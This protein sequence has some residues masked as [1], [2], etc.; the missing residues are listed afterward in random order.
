MTLLQVRISDGVNT[1]GI[2]T[3]STFAE[4][5][6]MIRLSDA[7]TLRKC[8]QGGRSAM[9]VT[10]L[11]DM[12]SLNTS[13]FH[14]ARPSLSHTLVGIDF[15]IGGWGRGFMGKATLPKGPA[16]TSS[17]APLRIP[18]KN[19]R[20]APNVLES[21]STRAPLLRLPPCFS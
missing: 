3:S 15:P 9:Y 6:A 12:S 8:D 13:S 2:D 4:T 11:G 16:E 17:S 19:L 1:A 7:S 10:F 20:R 14:T 18:M 5:A 21:K